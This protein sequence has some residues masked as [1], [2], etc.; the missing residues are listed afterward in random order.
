MSIQNRKT[1]PSA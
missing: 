1:Q